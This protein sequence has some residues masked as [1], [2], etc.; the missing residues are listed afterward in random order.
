[1]SYKFKREEKEFFKQLNFKKRYLSDKSGYWFE[2]NFKTKPIELKLLVDGSLI[3]LQ[4]KV[5]LLEFG[6]Q[7]S[8]FEDIYMCSY[9]IY[10]LK[11]VLIKYN[12]YGQ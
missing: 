1:M 12:L 2:K 9:S 5:H 4:C 8:Q 7:K 6:K 3:C 10:K 11:K